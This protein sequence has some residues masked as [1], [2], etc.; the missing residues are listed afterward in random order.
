MS[1]PGNMYDFR[2]SMENLFA[3]CR[4]F[5]DLFHPCYLDNFLPYTRQ[6][7]PLAL[8][9]LINL[10]DRPIKRTISINNDLVL[11]NGRSRTKTHGPAIK[12]TK[13]TLGII[14]RLILAAD[15]YIAR[16]VEPAVSVLPPLSS[17]LAS[18]RAPSSSFYLEAA[19]PLD[20]GTDRD[21][22]PEDLR[23]NVDARE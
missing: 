1:I 4:F 20:L 12:V 22:A 21:C 16:S 3:N 13:V 5:F 7:A 17:S 10:C 18:G 15:I 6:F 14:P 8:F 11:T 19:V 23:W 2:C 9:G